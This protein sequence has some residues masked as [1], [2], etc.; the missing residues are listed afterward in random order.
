[1]Q[2]ADANGYYCVATIGANKSSLK[3]YLIFL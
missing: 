3:N 2:L 1:L